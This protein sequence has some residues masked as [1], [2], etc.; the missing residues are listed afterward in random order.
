MLVCCVCDLPLT[1]TVKSRC[2]ELELVVMIEELKKQFFG[3]FYNSILTHSCL[4][5]PYQESIRK[6]DCGIQ[7]VELAVEGCAGAYFITRYGLKRP[8][9]AFRN[10]MATFLIVPLIY[11]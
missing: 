6:R 3:D 10:S 8:H 2:G 4:F 5:Q 7:G 1:L 11:W 9:I